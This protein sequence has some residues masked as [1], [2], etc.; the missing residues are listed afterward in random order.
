M[1][2]T[3]LPTQPTVSRF[4]DENGIPLHPEVGRTNYDG[5]RFNP[6]NDPLY[7]DTSH[8][9]DAINGKDKENL[10]VFT[11]MDQNMSGREEAGRR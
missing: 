9:V 1:A 10:Y 3:D 7:T 2:T 5:A 11:N 4:E 8:S 6:F